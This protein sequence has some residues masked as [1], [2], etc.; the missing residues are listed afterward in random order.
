MFSSSALP[1]FS[2]LCVLI[3][4]VSGPGEFRWAPTELEGHRDCHGGDPGCYVFGHSF[5][6]PPH[7]W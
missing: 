5:G 1:A 6:H 3:L 7:T 2:C 4:F